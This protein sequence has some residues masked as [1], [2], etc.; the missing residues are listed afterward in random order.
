MERFRQI[1]QRYRQSIDGQN[2]ARLQPM[3]ARPV[4]F[5]TEAGFCGNLRRTR[6]SSVAADIIRRR[7]GETPPNVRAGSQG[8][9][10]DRAR[11]KYD[12]LPFNF[13]RDPVPVAG[14]VSYPLVMVINPSVPTS[15][16]GEF[17]AYANMLAKSLWPR[18]AQA[19]RVIWPASFSKP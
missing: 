16:V 13:L 2:L 8:L 4:L 5:R 6:P 12:A 3:M 1:F 18:M 10:D 7:Y 14:L 9:R 15:T 11:P 19:R 17:I